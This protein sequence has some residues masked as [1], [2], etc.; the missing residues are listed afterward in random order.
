MNYCLSCVGGGQR[1]LLGALALADLEKQTGKLSREIFSYVSGTSTGALLAGAVAA[2]IPASVMVDLYTN[3]TNDVF[4]PSSAILSDLEMVERGHK[5]DIANLMKLLVS[6]FGPA[7]NW[8]MND[9]QIGIMIAA[10]AA[11]GHDW[12]FVKDGPRNA[13]TTGGVSLLE[14]MCASAAATTYFDPQR[15][16]LSS[17]KELWFF[18]GGVGGVANPSYQTGVEMFEHDLFAPIQTRMWTLGTGFYPVA[19]DADIAP[20]KGLI[21]GIEFATDTLVDSSEDWVDQATARQ[22]PGVPTKIDWVLPAA[23]AMDDLS[24][25]PTLAAVYKANPTNW[26]GLLGL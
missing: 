16:T 13:K 26:K 14:A 20:P 24:A 2:G 8:S 7:K 23:I 11:N 25:I 3:H 22:W 9:C 18:D 10:V 6:T 5:Y 21:N 17:G 15:V 12:F 4:R 19:A 1:G